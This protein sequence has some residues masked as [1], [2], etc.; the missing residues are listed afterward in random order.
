M[1]GRRDPFADPALVRRVYAY[2]AYRIGA[3]P[4]A[5]DVTG[6]VFER[7]IRYRTRY[8]SSRGTPLTWLLAIARNAVADQ[9]R[10]T[11]EPL[12][13]ANEPPV[14]GDVAE[15]VAQRMILGAAVARLGD[16]DRDLIA[17]RYGADLSA[18]E[19][20]RLLELRTNAVEVALHRA[21][22]RLRADLRDDGEDRAAAARSVSI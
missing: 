7:A 12:D 8:D 13:E 17:L 4:D 21:L 6:D 9:R 16:R 10:P 20:A 2:V 1:I 15:D 18:R 3:G 19:I 5:E 11:V 22:A 14:P